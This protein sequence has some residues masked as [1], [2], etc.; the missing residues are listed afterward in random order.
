MGGIRENGEQRTEGRLAPPQR[1]E[2]RKQK[3]EAPLRG[4]GGSGGEGRHK[5][6]RRFRRYRRFRSARER[7][8]DRLRYKAAKPP[9]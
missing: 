7:A 4:D 9:S 5:S 2:N 1:T 6:H 8:T 3:T